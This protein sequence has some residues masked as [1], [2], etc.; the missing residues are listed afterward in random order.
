MPQSKGLDFEIDSL[1]EE[2]EPGETNS[3]IR[4][5]GIPLIQVKGIGKGTA[6]NLNAQGVS[7]IEDLLGADPDELSSK[8]SGASSKMVSEWQKNAKILL[9]I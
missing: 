8:I 1:Y 9:K 3:N 7:T 2:S 4:D 5:E 6:E